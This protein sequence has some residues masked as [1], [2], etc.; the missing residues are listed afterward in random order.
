MYLE[1]SQG[2][3][4]PGSPSRGQTAEVKSPSP[5]Q[6]D[7]K[8]LSDLKNRVKVRVVKIKQQAGGSGT[9]EGAGDQSSTQA[10]GS[11]AA[12]TDPASRGQ[13]TLELPPEKK[14]E[15]ENKMKTQL[16]KA[17]MDTQG[18]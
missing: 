14:A 2:K 7:P 8:A 5:S 16:E 18:K 9:S 3:R 10:P 17:G 12:T 11:E 13:Q 15:L 4:D 1:T 6:P